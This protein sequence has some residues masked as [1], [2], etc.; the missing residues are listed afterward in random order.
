MAWL[1]R[2][3]TMIKVFVK[4]I[5]A[6]HQFL[7]SSLEGSVSVPLLVPYPDPK[8]HAPTNIA[9]S[10]CLNMWVEFEV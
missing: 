4:R 2:C 10:A 7:L 6:K 1:C 8:P 9:H 5:I 3:G